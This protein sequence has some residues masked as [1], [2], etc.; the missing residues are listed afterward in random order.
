MWSS[1]EPEQ[2]RMA[3]PISA[4]RR[5]AF[6]ETYAATRLAR[7][8]VLIALAVASISMEV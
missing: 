1:N 3:H 6:V 2:T 8:C 7:K 4:I 5:G